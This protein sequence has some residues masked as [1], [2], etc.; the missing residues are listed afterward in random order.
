M[1]FK[2][3]HAADIH[4][5]S[6]LV[7]LERYEG[8]PVRYV[9]AATRRAFQN[10][11]DLAL[12]EGVDFVVVAGD[13]YDGDW[14]DYSTGLFF[15]S[16]M[17][18][19]RE[20]G[21]R[22]FIA[23]GNHDA[24]NLITRQL[25]LPD[26]VQDLSTD[27][28][29]TVE[30]DDLGVAVHGQGFKRQAVTEDLSRNYPNP[31]PGYFNIG[32]LH[33]CA[34]GREGHEHYAP[35]DVSYLAAKGYDYWALG[36]VHRR[37]ELGREPWILFPG[38]TQGRHVRE[39]GSKGCTLVRVVDGRVEAVEHRSL[40]V[41]RWSVCVVNAGGAA[42]SDEILERA[43]RAFQ[44]LLTEAGDRLL[45]V[46]FEITGACLAHAGLLKNP[47]RL[48]A[49]LRQMVSDLGVGNAWV[50]KVKIQTR[51]IVDAVAV[52]GQHPVADVLHYIR[53]LVESEEALADLPELQAIKNAL[54]PDFYRVDD[55]NPGD[56]DY[57]RQ[58]LPQ[59]EELIVS[60][61]LEKEESSGEA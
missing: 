19:L 8:A 34:T 35:C 46:R 31:I 2:F 57:L 26:N 52:L 40:D 59:V 58:L 15:A 3:I 39:G 37:E 5:D 21:I 13:L 22:V 4:L 53:K 24:A 36:H 30:W 11:V 49:N 44:P 48:V 56:S 23:R 42:G 12:E 25:R 50:E 47:E 51:P 9:R 60:R 6:P 32:V 10:L 17:A 38:N 18:R 54:P 28:P 61:L 33:T 29:E 55:V 7:G 45:A 16:Q 41:L 27:D 14:R 43:T 1:Q 20:A